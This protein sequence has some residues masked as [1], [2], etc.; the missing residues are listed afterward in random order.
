MKLRF[1]GDTDI[2]RIREE[3]GDPDFRL[4]YSKIYDGEPW[5]RFCYSVVD[6]SGEAH[7]YQRELFE[8]VSAL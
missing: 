4:T 5:N 7:F 8:V 1:R 6:D 2:K 3:S